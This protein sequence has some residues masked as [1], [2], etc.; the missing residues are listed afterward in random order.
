MG[1]DTREALGRIDLDAT[2]ERIGIPLRQKN[3]WARF[4]SGSLPS[5]CYRESSAILKVR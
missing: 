5:T 4:G 1:V 2:A 3:R